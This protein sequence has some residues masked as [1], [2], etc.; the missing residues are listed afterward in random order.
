MTLRKQLLRPGWLTRPAQ[1]PPP[2][3]PPLLTKN[4]VTAAL[5]SV[6][7]QLLSRPAFIQT[8]LLLLLLVVAQLF[9][10]NGNTDSCCC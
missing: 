1:L 4:G 7:V 6:A 5:S 8:F 2:L 3:P 10:S 9:A